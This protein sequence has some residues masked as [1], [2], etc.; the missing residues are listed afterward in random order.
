LQE[1]REKGEKVE[2]ETETNHGHME[3]GGEGKRERG[4]ESKKSED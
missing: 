3:R 4:L 1:D 2:R